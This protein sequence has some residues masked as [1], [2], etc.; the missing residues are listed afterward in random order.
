MLS[1]GDRAWLEQRFKES[2]DE[3]TRQWNFANEL[4]AEFKVHVANSNAKHSIPCSTADAVM[5]EHLKERHN[6]KRTLGVIGLIL[7]AAAAFGEAVHYLREWIT[8][9]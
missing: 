5:K 3:S 7:G 1:D 2:R 4:N 9:K 8:K 6:P